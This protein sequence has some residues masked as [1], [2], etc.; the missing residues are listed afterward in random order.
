M[1][2]EAIA[3]R[4]ESRLTLSLTHVIAEHIAPATQEAKLIGGRHLRSGH[5]WCS[6]VQSKTY[7][8]S[9]SG[10]GLRV[11]RPVLIH[12]SKAR[13][14]NLSFLLEKNTIAFQV[15]GIFV[16]VSVIMK[17]SAGWR[18]GSTTTI[19]YLPAVSFHQGS[20][21]ATRD[22]G[23][24]T[25]QAGGGGHSQRSSAAARA[26]IVLTGT[27]GGEKRMSV[28]TESKTPIITPTTSQTIPVVRAP[29]D[30]TPG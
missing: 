1:L 22:T 27:G 6:L 12:G 4:K 8:G 30:M 9:P 28:I 18:R 29:G 5:G 26:I 3:N 24:A 14:K 10:K 13:C 15:G 11:T 17:M 20:V 19:P 16:S 21:Q 23:R 7:P 2:S 25:G